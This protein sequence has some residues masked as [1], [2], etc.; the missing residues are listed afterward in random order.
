MDRMTPVVSEIKFSEKRLPA[1][2][3]VRLYSTL[4]PQAVDTVRLFPSTPE[5]GG[6]ER[7]RSHQGGKQRLRWRTSRESHPSED[8]SELPPLL[9]SVAGQ[10]YHC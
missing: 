3:S 4:L 1:C 10:E 9:M 8:L 5:G 2:F 7:C 6:R